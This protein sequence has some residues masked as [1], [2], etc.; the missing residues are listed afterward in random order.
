MT[1]ERLQN[2]RGLVRL[3]EAWKTAWPK[4]LAQLGQ[5]T[6]TKDQMYTWAVVENAVCWELTVA[7]GN[8]QVALL[9]HPSQVARGPSERWRS[10]VEKT[11][12]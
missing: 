2:S 4:L 8:E 7:R 12:R 1:A 11:R 10:C 5:P 6:R 9:V 3:R